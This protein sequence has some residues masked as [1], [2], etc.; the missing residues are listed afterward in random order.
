MIDWTTVATL[1][2]A[3]GTL[4][5]AVAT[6]ASVRLSNRTARLMERSLIAGLHPVLV[7][8][9]PDHPV[10][11]VGFGDNRFFSVPGGRAIA[12]VGDDAIYLVMSVRNVGSGLAVLHAWTAHPG[13]TVGVAGHEP[14]DR[15][16]RLTR[17]L[18]VPAGDVSFW[19]GAFRDPQDPLYE[20][21]ARTIRE[22]EPFTV[23]ILYG[24]LEGGQRVITRFVIQPAH[25]EGWMHAVTRHWNLDRPNPR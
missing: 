22:R 7:P 2:T 5:L 24:D 17:D 14:V 12:E 16:R 18:Y 3:G 13:R 23:E 15:F 1:A 11:K 8:S 4:V 9:R 25:D 10:E 6:F 21:M 19:E 20:P